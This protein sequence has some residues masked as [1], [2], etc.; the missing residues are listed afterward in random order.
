[1]GGFPQGVGDGLAVFNKIFRFDEVGVIGA[2]V[3]EQVFIAQTMDAHDF[4]PSASSFFLVA[5]YFFPGSRFGGLVTF[6]IQKSL[7]LI[8]PGKCAAAEFGIRNPSVFHQTPWGQ[9]SGADHQYLAKVWGGFVPGELSFAEV[10]CLPG[11]R[12][13]IPQVDFFGKRHTDGLFCLLHG[14]TVFHRHG[15]YMVKAFRINPV[16][17]FY[18]SAVP[19]DF[20]LLRELEENNIRILCR[21]FVRIQGVIAGA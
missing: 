16:N 2:M 10:V 21:A 8:G 9:I 12:G 14:N 5:V 4:K 17:V 15:L 19:D 18:E 11:I 13:Y 6:A 20:R 1:M 7:L 3:Y